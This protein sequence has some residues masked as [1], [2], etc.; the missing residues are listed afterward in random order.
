MCGEKVVEAKEVGSMKGSEE[1]REVMTM[2]P[3]D[4]EEGLRCWCPLLEFDILW[5]LEQFR[6]RLY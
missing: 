2:F 5:P 4:P 3:S 6:S 1:R